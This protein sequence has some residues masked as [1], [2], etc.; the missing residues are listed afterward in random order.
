MMTQVFSMPAR[1]EN[2]RPGR[3]IEW[4]GGLQLRRRA[5]CQAGK[6]DRYQFSR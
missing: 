1:L 5:D 2:G 4:H 6:D 3:L